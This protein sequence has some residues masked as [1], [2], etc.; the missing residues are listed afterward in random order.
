MKPVYVNHDANFPVQHL[1]SDA[2][3][4][5]NLLKPERYADDDLL[6]LSVIM[7]LYGSPDVGH[8]CLSKFDERRGS[9]LAIQYMSIKVGG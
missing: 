6:R 8:F 3:F 4:V 9:D 7:D 1:W 2:V 5:R